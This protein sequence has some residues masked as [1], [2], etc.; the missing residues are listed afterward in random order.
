MIFSLP[1]LFDY[2][3]CLDLNNEGNYV[4]F[5]DN[6]QTANHHSIIFGIR[7]LNEV[8]MNRFCGN[9]VFLRPTL[10]E[11]FHFTSDYQLRLYQSACFY[12]DEYN[13]WQSDGLL[14][15]LFEKIFLRRTFSYLR[16]DH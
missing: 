1:S 9:D 8:E 5:L 2:S 11:P 6:D 15:S 13:Q 10:T 12:L 4:Y 14:V 16:L 7:Q 3:D